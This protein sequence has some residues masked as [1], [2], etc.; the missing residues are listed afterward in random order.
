MDT[1]GK[2]N[3]HNK[4]KGDTTMKV[5]FKIAKMNL[6]EEKE[7]FNLEGLEISHEFQGKEYLSYISF[8]TKM[9]TMCFQLFS[10]MVTI[11]VRELIDAKLHEKKS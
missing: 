4:N 5:S 8:C 9:C 1:W 6:V 3:H 11:V 10:K 2:S 7:N